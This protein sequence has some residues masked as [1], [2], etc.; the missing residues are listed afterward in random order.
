VRVTA[1]TVAPISR[2][3]LLDRDRFLFTDL[4]RRT[5]TVVF[6][7]SRGSELS[8]EMPTIANGVFTE[9][10]LRALTGPGDRFVPIATARDEVSRAVAT[11]TNDLQHPVIDRDN[12]D[13]RLGLPRVPSAAAIADRIDIA[14]P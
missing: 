12:P 9:H 5:G 1:K 7:S 10:L 3:Y 11:T 6:S 4:S 2:P 8:W 14:R 13:A